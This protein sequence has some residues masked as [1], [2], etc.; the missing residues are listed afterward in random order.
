MD[1]NHLTNI[2]ASFAEVAKQY[3]Q[4]TALSYLGTGYSYAEVEDMA[5]RF[6]AGLLARGLAPGAKV[7][8]Y[9]PNSIQWVVAWLGIQRAGCVAVP[10]T[11]IYTPYDLAYI[12]NDTGAE[13]VV[14]VDRNYGYVTKV[15]E[16]TKI[17]LV[18]TSGLAD[19]LPAYKRWFGF[20]FD[21]VPKGRTAKA[22]HT[23]N[24]RELLADGSGAA[25][26]CTAGPEELAEI[27]Y[28]G[29]TTKHPKGVPIP[30]G[31]LLQCARE[32][33]GYSADAIPPADNV[34][35]GTAPVF[36]VLGQ[37]CALGTIFTYGGT[38][39][40]QPRVNL[41]AMLHAV[42]SLGGRTMIG[43]PTLYRM[44]LEHDRL[45][46]F[47]LSSLD[48]CFSGGDVLPLEVSRRWER[49]FGK[50][51]YIGYGSTETVGG[52]AMNPAN[53]ETPPGCM[54]IVLPS[55]VVQVIDP[56]T[57]EEVPYGKPGELLVHSAPMVDAYWN[58][59]EET[60]QAFVMRDDKIFYRTGDI[61]A[62]DEERRL[63]FVDRTMDTIKHK[64]YRVSATEIEA[65]LQ[66]HPAVIESCV[67]GL[68]DEKVGERI[69][70]FVVLKKDAKGITGYDL[71]QFCRKRLVNYKIPQY[72]EFRDMLPKSKVGKLLRREI[73]A[74]EAE[75]REES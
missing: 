16:N 49:R 75:R 39:V 24:I 68:P 67:V 69:K 43:V 41:D 31:L 23:V 8:I 42:E 7:V 63:Y 17:K 1:Q 51:I 58:K 37:T 35:L 22:A 36:H 65:T 74:E 70:A 15:M 14:C 46:Q 44:I 38:L 13:A 19:L 9:M 21:K 47:D 52:V 66:E 30:H 6:A 20:V 60:R 12:A 72:I 56:G 54:G 25:P 45:D 50:R 61:V 10:I 5:G 3:P 59:P 32:Q 2:P 48:Y 18:V 33:L 34:I 53:K 64:G 11:P 26:T 55:K 28:T 4:K 29:G 71:I 62:M 27:L 40:L 57:L 73:R